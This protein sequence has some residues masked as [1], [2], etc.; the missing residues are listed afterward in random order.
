MNRVD[1]LV[2]LLLQRNNQL[3]TALDSRVVIEQ[4]KG[5][6]KERLGIGVEDAFA[7]LRVAARRNRIKLR[8]LAARV[9]AEPET[10]P[11]IEEALSRRPAPA[12]AREL[13]RARELGGIRIAENEAFFRS[14]NEGLVGR[15]VLPDDALIA[16]LCECGDEDCLDAIALTRAEYE[17]VR[18]DP[19]VF[20]VAPAVDHVVHGSQDRLRRAEVHLGHEG[21]DGLGKQAPLEPAGVAEVFQPDQVEGGGVL[22]SAGGT[23]RALTGQLVDGR[24]VGAEAPQRRDELAGRADRLDG[25]S[26]DDGRTRLLDVGG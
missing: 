1:E 9:V 14:L 25:G 24:L 23:R 18:Q 17:A 11:E 19:T 12:D 16:F 3:Q 5:I 22:H 13:R 10:P 8:D 6:L 7:L 15:S 26:G 20:A 2:R 21:A 4:A